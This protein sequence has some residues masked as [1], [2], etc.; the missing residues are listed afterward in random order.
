MATRT[1]ALLASGFV[2]FGLLAAPARAAIDI[3]GPWNVAISLGIGPPLATCIVD[4]VQTGSALTISAPSG[5]YVVPAFSLTGTID[6]GTGAFTV[7]GTGAPV[8]ATL[9]VDG[10]ANSTSTGFSGNFACTGGV[11]KRDRYAGRQPVRER[12]RQSGRA[13]RPRLVAECLL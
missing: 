12:G 7:S 13:V 8:C 6:T 9:S 2:C 1:A 10:T 11:L 4:V 3:N 5:C